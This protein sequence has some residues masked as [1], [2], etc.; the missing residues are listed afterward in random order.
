ME[1][2][3]PDI[4]HIDITNLINNINEMSEEELNICRS[5][6]FEHI[7]D[8]I[9]NIIAIRSEMTRLLLIYTRIAMVHNIRIM[10]KDIYN[11]MYNENK[12]TTLDE[13]K[14]LTTNV[15]YYYTI[16]Y[17]DDIEEEILYKT[18][19]KYHKHIKLLLSIYDTFNEIMNE[20]ERDEK[21]VMT[22]EDFNKLQIVKIDELKQEDKTCSICQD[23]YDTNDEIVIL[24]CNNHHFHKNC[25]KNWLMNHSNICPLCRMTIE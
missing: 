20:R 4:I 13:L 10:I 12:I 24:K 5:N 22:E 25:I 11:F 1:G 16:Y 6:M 7:N 19:E 2:I 17:G 18:I 21:R 8:D 15:F 3:I 9:Q 14:T 23:E